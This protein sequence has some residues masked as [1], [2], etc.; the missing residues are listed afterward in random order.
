[1]LLW[2]YYYFNHMAIMDKH[3]NYNDNMLTIKHGLDY[4]LNLFQDECH[5]HGWRSINYGLTCI[6]CM[7]V[8]EQNQ[9]K[10]VLQQCGSMLNHI[11]IKNSINQPANV[12]FSSPGSG[13]GGRSQRKMAQRCF[14]SQTLLQLLLGRCQM[15]FRISSACSGSA[16]WSSPSWMHP[17]YLHR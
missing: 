12:H 3:V 17:E 8:D 2:F 13:H 15:G 10:C 16:L 6:Q 7:S 5:K 4:G 9:I 11:L 14:S 1:M